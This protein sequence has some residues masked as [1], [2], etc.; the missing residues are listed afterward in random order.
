M[1]PNPDIEDRR[2]K[3]IAASVARGTDPADILKELAKFD[4]D[5]FVS[6]GTRIQDLGSGLSYETSTEL[7]P[8]Q[9]FISPTEIATI[10]VTPNQAAKLDELALAKDPA[11]YDYLDSIRLAP[12]RTRQP[13]GKA[14]GEGAEP[15]AEGAGPSGRPATLRTV[16]EEAQ[17]L[18]YRRERGTLSAKEQSDEAKN[19]FA[20]GSDANSL[21]DDLRVIRAIFDPKNKYSQLLTGKF[22]QGDI[23][24]QIG[25]LLESGLA[26]EALKEAARKIATNLDLPPLAVTQ[27]Q[28]AVSRMADLKL[29]ASRI[30]EGQGTVTEAERRLIAES[31]IGITDTPKTILA[32]AEYLNARAR[33]EARRSEMLRDFRDDRRDYNDFVRSEDYKRLKKNYEL[34]LDQIVERRLGVKL[35]PRDAG[36]RDNAGAASRLPETVR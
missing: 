9:V 10:N 36:G 22:E 24:S 27:F 20:R 14:P 3:F 25:T 30:M 11:Y 18:N 1:P 23:K 31:V 29:K 26:G 2:N 13:G 32:K 35:P 7:K 28:M 16:E 4:K 34:E 6:I 5:R 8:K 17:D 33:F 19:W 12:P 21:I 15:G